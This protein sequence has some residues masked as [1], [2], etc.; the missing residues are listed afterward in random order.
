MISPTGGP[1]QTMDEIPR[2]PRHPAP[3]ADFGTPIEAFLEK[4][5][6]ALRAILDE[7]LALIK[8]AAPDAQ[9]STKWG[10]AFFTVD[11]AMMGAL[12]AHKSHVNLVLSGPPEAFSDPA[13]PPTGTSEN[14]RHLKVTDMTEIPRDEVLD[15]VR[16]AADL[17]RKRV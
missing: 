15:W 11:G 17:A 2:S 13:H 3:R 8:E 4:Q 14:G 1:A 12:T 7:L 9:S 16:T 5:P 10:N 6:V